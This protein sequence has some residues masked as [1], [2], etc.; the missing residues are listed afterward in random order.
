M[1]TPME[2]LG[3]DLATALRP[4]P[5]V[6][7]RARQR[8][9]L[10]AHDW[11]S[12]RGLPRWLW[13]V[14]AMAV[15]MA[16]VVFARRR[17]ERAAGAI[18]EIA[19]DEAL[20]Q[21][22]WVRVP[23]DHAIKLRFT[24]GTDLLLERKSASRLA[25]GPGEGRLTLEEGRLTAW[26]KPAA[27]TGRSWTFQ[28]G[29]YEVMVIG[30]ELEIAWSTETSRLAV[31][32]AH[33]RVRVRGG[34][35]EG[36]GL[37]LNAGDHLEVDR[38]R[39][40]VHQGQALPPIG[41]APPAVAPSESARAPAD[42]PGADVQPGKHE[43]PPTAATHDVWKSQARAG[44]YQEA[45]ASAEREGFEA[46]TQHLGASDL[47][48]LADAARLAGDGSRARQAL[49]TLRRRFPSVDVAH[50]AAFRLARLALADHDYREASR[51]FGTYLEEA[52]SGPLASEAAG[53]LVEARSRAGDRAGAEA[54]A[55]E[56]LRR[57]PGG[58]Y[59]SVANALLRGDS[60]APRE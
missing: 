16:I 2:R 44:Q 9:R 48:L 32:V 57:F 34:Q 11:D 27:I 60:L 40:E 58:P 28:A 59:A 3:K 15:V 13:A 8:A 47:A 54:A 41:V 21:G 12:K 30:T 5:S 43:A 37:I 29:P 52:P 20:T 35:L 14:P 45:L 4:G 10:L 42:E 51:W 33:G 24:D 25:E 46:L 22:R 26:V 19:A 39:V 31:D 18:V 53:R 17:V 38:G 1:T 55:R 49:Q 6:E 56:Y 36:E 50:T 23:D 7:R